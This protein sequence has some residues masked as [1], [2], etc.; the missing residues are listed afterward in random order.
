LRWLASKPHTILNDDFDRPQTS[1]SGGDFRWVANG[2]SGV[3]AELARHLHSFPNPRFRDFGY[4]D[5]RES[6]AM[7]AACD[8]IAGKL[9]GFSRQ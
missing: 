7:I 1:T 9:C 6:S 2:K 5:I 8:I 4:H 3:V